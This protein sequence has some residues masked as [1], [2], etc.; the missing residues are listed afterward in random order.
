MQ[1]LFRSNRVFFYELPDNTF[2]FSLH[3][4]RSEQQGES[5]TYYKYIMD[6]HD[7]FRIVFLGNTLEDK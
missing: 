4:T 7:L 1:H 3:A 5:Y 6:F 2:S